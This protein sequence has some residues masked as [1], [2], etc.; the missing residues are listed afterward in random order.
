MIRHVC[1]NVARATTV[2]R[3][4]VATDDERIAEAVRAGGCEVVM[5][6]SDLPSGTDRIAAAMDELG[7]EG[8]VLNVQGDEPMIDPDVIDRL[9]EGFVQSGAD[10]ATPVARIDSI[11]YLFDPDTPKVVMRDDM[12]AIYFSRTPIPFLRD[13]APEEWLDHHTF[14]RHIGLYIYRT[15]ALRR[16][17]GA[18]PSRIEQ[19][20]QLEQLRALAL[21]MSIHC[22][23]VEYNGQA[24]DSAED[25]MRVESLLSGVI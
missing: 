5:T 13:Y 25:V 14:H 8:N 23:E 15:E 9:V 1:E 20:E 4:V 21:G 16:F 7:I 18:T 19:I 3:V 24:V 12:T 10:C 22:V 6:G 17:V 2:D 11:S